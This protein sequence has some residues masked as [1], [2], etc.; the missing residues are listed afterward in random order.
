MGREEVM[1]KT[2]RGQENKGEVMWEGK[3][4]DRQRIKK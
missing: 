2:E 3:L 4:R 1:R